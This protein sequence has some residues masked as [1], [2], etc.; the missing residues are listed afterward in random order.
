MSFNFWQGISIVYL[1]SYSV[2]LGVILL[3]TS[4][5]QKILISPNAI[6]GFGN[7]QVLNDNQSLDPKT[8]SNIKDSQGENYSIADA[9]G[10]LNAAYIPPTVIIDLGQ[11]Y[12]LS[13]IYY[14]FYNGAGA[15]E[16]IE[17]YAGSP[18]DW[19]NQPFY[20]NNTLGFDQW[21]GGQVSKTTRY[22][23]LVMAN[24][25][26]KVR[27]LIL[28]GNQAV[29]SSFITAANGDWQQ[30]NTWQNNSIPPTTGHAII[31]HKVNINSNTSIASA[32]ME[33]PQACLFIAP[34]ARLT[35]GMVSQTSRLQQVKALVDQHYFV[36]D[37]K[38]NID[39]GG[40]A[41]SPGS[42]VRSIV[43]KQ[44]AIGGLFRYQSEKEPSLAD[45]IPN[46]TYPG[47]LGGIPRFFSENGG[48][49]SIAN[50]TD[51]RYSN[52]VSFEQG[53][54]FEEIHVLRLHGGQRYE[55]IISSQGNGY[56]NDFK[57]WAN[58]QFQY[59]PWAYGDVN[60]SVL[61]YTYADYTTIILGFKTNPVLGTVEIW[62]TDSLGDTRTI[63]TGSIPLGRKLQIR[64]IGTSSHPHSFD[65]FGSCFKFTS[66]F[67]DNDR[68]LI[69]QL[70]KEEYSAGQ[71]PNKSFARPTLA[72]NGAVFQLTPNYV[73]SGGASTI[74]T[75]RTVIN[76]YHM[77]K[78]INGLP[79]S[80]IF[81][82]IKWVASTTGQ[83]LNFDTSQIPGFELGVDQ[84]I[85]S[86]FVYD[87]LGK[88]FERDC[89]TNKAF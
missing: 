16:L 60:L 13:D 79:V 63:Y 78:N 61:N 68:N 31:R 52:E 83:Q 4:Y 74:D 18:A 23:K 25:N 55:A 46:R 27:E 73:L 35:V 5:C 7:P 12:N 45:P 76:W 1:K 53:T 58:G 38:E 70:L 56:Y 42:L 66:F 24:T 41:I 59:R 26:I 48:Y 51:I 72:R 69:N 34:N 80:D 19:E 11:N 37:G 39:G 86:I 29:A 89:E 49:L 47:N 32:N 64:S 88:G 85:A 71:V 28:Y 17:F 2:L 10:Y 44:G 30:N 54:P 67:S 21:K 81:Q 75:Q 84:M 87:N 57:S 36:V 15:T 77:D 22:I 33:G 50:G 6:S 65:W 14:Y 8:N 9:N 40:S 82:H 20:S 3:Q 62:V 43:G